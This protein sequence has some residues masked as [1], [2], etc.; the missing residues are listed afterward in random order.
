MKKL[1]FEQDDFTYKNEWELAQAKH[2]KW[3]DELM[4]SAFVVYKYKGSEHADWSRT[5]DEE[6]G[7]I[8][9]YTHQGLLIDVKK[10]E[11]K[12]EHK[13]IKASV[14]IKGGDFGKATHYHQVPE[15]Y[16]CLDCGMELQPTGWRAK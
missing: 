12:C 6:F 7:G 2:D 3:W 8:N 9:K 1:I 15:Q 11:K 13:K 16:Y 14:Y 10:I 4:A 5:I